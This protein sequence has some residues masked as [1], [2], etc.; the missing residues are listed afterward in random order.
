MNK[1]HRV[2]TAHPCKICG[3]GDWCGYNDEGA[4]C[5]MRIASQ[6]PARNGG[7]IHATTEPIRHATRQP[8]QPAPKYDAPDFN[9]EKWWVT[10]RR[11]A[12]WDKMQAWAD[13]LGLPIDVL[14]VMGGCHLGDMLAFPMHDGYGNVCGIRTR[15]PDGSKRSVTGSR[16]G[17]FLPTLDNEGDPVICEGPTDA[18][19]AFALGFYPI[20]RPSCSGS[21]RHV[22]DTCRRLGIDKATICA[23]SDGPGIAGARKLADVLNAARIQVR[24]VTAGGHKDLRDWFKSGVTPE[25]VNAA[26]E[27]AEWRS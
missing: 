25:I 2:T 12:N 13:K 4:V 15:N 23:D 3:K 24:M 22:V 7:W 21:E 27:Q 14:D 18:A 19:A 11:V 6:K 9:A 20:G 16:A 26:W 17:L 1:W 10:V 8:A 5:C